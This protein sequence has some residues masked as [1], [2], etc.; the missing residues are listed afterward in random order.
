M[1]AIGTTVV[2]ALEA[3]ALGQAGLATLRID[4]HH[5]LRVVDG[6]VSGLHVP[7]ESHF[8]LLSAFAPRRTL[9]RALDAAIAAGLSVRIRRCVPDH[10]EV[11]EAL[12]RADDPRAL[13]SLAVVPC[14][15]PR[16]HRAR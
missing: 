13:R 16:G 5:A 14:R 3:D 7:G 4:G 9:V 1:I 6:L 11:E 2:R 15:S 8:E 12:D 10:L